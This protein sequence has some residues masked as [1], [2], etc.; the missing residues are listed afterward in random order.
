V[1][2]VQSFTTAL[3]ETTIG[4]PSQPRQATSGPIGRSRASHVP[5]PLRRPGG[6]G[7]GRFVVADWVVSTPPWQVETPVFYGPLKECRRADIE[8][9]GGNARSQSAGAPSALPPADRV[10]T[11][12]LVGYPESHLG[13][14]MT[15]R[16]PEITRRSLPPTR[17]GPEI[18]GGRPEITWGCPAITRF[19]PE[20]TRGGS[21]PARGNR[22]DEW[23]GRSSGCRRSAG[24]PSR[25]ETQYRISI[26]P[27]L[28]CPT[29]SPRYPCAPFVHRC[30]ICCLRAVFRIRQKLTAMPG[31]L[32]PAPG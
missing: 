30:G 29:L 25:L 18:T 15:P 8:A 2:T 9:A 21:P 13:H 11:P 14:P 24:R 7:P 19:G 6:G 12:A 26:D 20:I 5:Q 16:C 3:S 1:E 23:L 32:Y 27:F 4:G 31:R 17:G 28:D 22:R 10:S